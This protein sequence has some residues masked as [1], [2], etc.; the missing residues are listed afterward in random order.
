V[1]AR[2]AEQSQ[3]VLT[4]TEAVARVERTIAADAVARDPAVAEGLAMAGVRAASL[5]DGPS[6]GA[7]DGI[8]VSE[9][10]C[11]HHVHAPPGHERGGAFELAASSVQQ[12]TDH[13]L[14]AHLLSRRLGRAGL[15]S[16]APSLARDLNLVSLPEPDLVAELLAA[17]AGAPEPDASPERIVDL[18][19]EV[20]RAVG[21][22]TA[23]PAN[24]VE[25]QGDGA[26]EV[27]LVAS[28]ADTAPAR[29][30]AR[31]L[32]EAGVAA[33]ALSVVLVR[34]FP[35]AEVREALRAS[36]LV[37]VVHASGEPS[38][39]LAPV[40][41]AVGEKTEVHPLAATDPAQMIEAVRQHLPAG[42]FEEQKL[43]A[44]P[45]EAPS[46]RLVVAPE[47]PWG[48]ET[49]RRAL[50]ALG[51][52][53]ALRVG[54]STGRQLGATVLHWE[55]AEIPEEGA[56]LLLVSYPAILEPE[57]ALTLIRPRSA[58]VLL[59]EAKSAQELMRLLRPETWQAFGEKEL[60]I[61]WVSP[62][63]APGQAPSDQVDCAAS[64]TLAG[65]ALT[66]V[67][68]PAD[69]AGMAEEISPSDD[70]ASRWLREGASAVQ[71]LDPAALDAAPAA[72]EL[73]FR[74]EPELPRMPDPVDDPEER[75]RQA[76]WIRRFHR[77]G[78]RTFDARQPGRV[79]AR[80]F[81]RSL[82]PR[83]LRR[84]RAADRGPGSS[85]AAGPGARR[86]GGRRLGPGCSLGE[87]RC[88]GGHRGAS[89]GRARPGRRAGGP[90][91]CSW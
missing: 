80:H 47:G 1:E 23:R 32:S 9:A 17:D 14:V 73:N 51:R 21:D 49:A 68:Q 35:K 57:G 54:R 83:P 3:A 6:I 18:A 89:A 87:P 61:Y 8:A 12:A 50:A 59:A 33:S 70:Q 79:L 20:L 15:C 41:G 55:S 48:E 11:V 43:A 45:E 16:L 2:L 13:C 76:H 28:G 66:A 29:E 58:V 91:L 42:S 64:L 44:A 86:H 65:A 27:V 31:A 82:R 4:G 19:R 34:P 63:I 30:A 38:A 90:P 40:R 26:A 22:R 81:A 60:R 77:L 52:L 84:R 37:L 69:P 74:S 25:I 85:G 67:R 72:E 10:S 5:V 39:M 88:A 36:R 62:P 78:A 71:T 24:L 75:Q 7:A 46:R 53:V 56:D